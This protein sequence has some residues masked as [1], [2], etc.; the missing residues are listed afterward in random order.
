MS[1]PKTGLTPAQRALIGAE[2]QTRQQALQ[3]QLAA[4]LHGSTRAERAH[5]VAQQDND[6]A[7][8][9]APERE[10]AMALTDHEQ[11]ELKAVTDALTRLPRDDFGVCADCDSPIPFDR[12]K[13]EPWALRCVE[14]ATRHERRRG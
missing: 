10:I 8:Q 4:H 13:A 2:L 1:R 11:T 6:D 14:C 5:E 9:R 7:P 3:R 12:L